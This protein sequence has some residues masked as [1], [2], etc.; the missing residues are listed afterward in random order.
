MAWALAKSSDVV[1]TPGNPGIAAHGISCVDTPATELDADLFVIGPDQQ[2]VDGL[3]DD[4]RAQGKTVVGPG[5][6][7]AQLEGSKAYLKEFLASANVPS[8]AYGIF[9]DEDAALA[10][11][12]DDEAAVRH[13]DRRPRGR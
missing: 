10:F 6:D 11:L 8:A 7:G 9:D 3:A 13:Q 2:V 12:R 1:V 5:A 4:L